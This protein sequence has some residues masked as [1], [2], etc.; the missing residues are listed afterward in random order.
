MGIM[1]F[2]VEP[3]ATDRYLV[4]STVVDAP[5][6][7][8]TRVDMLRWLQPPVGDLDPARARAVMKRVD[9]TGTSEREGRGAWEDLEPIPVGEDLC[10]SDGWYRMSRENLPALVDAIAS[11]DREAIHQ[12]LVRYA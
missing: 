10:P 11:G 7:I 8:G 3:G 12:L 9:E 1:I 5:I 6:G 2:K 4:W